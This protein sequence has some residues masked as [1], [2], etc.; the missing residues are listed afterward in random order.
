[1]NH[2]IMRTITVVFSI[3]F[4]TSCSSKET[5]Q[6]AEGTFV[7]GSKVYKIVD[8]ELS[9]IGD[10]NSDSIRKFQVTEPVKREFGDDDIYFVKDGASVSLDALYR[11]NTLYYNFYL[12]GLNDLK[13]SYESGHFIVQFLDEHGFILHST[14]IPTNELT[15][16]VQGAEKTVVGY[17]TN[18]KTEMSSDIYKA[19]QNYTVSSTVK[20][21]STSS[22]WGW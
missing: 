11:G 22:F 18:G 1:M 17:S 12:S 4:L 6:V 16:T 15:A 19:I 5:T 3:L 2:Q 13:D 10:L 14:T 7:H 9:E 8:N 20:P 21:K